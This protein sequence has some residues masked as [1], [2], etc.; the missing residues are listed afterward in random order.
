[1]LSRQKEKERSEGDTLLKV[2]D[3]MVRE[4]VT[5]NEDYSVKNAA[6]IMNKFEI[7]SL[8]VVNEGKTV[9]IMTERDVLKRVVAESRDA[10]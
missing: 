9:G 5:V 2:E 7:G 1:M 10:R 6:E 4:V 3:V 8:I